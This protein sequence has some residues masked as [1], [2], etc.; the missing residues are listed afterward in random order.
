MPEATPSSP[1]NPAAN[2]LGLFS[3]EEI[4]AELVRRS[5]ALLVIRRFADEEHRFKQEIRCYFPPA[6][7]LQ[8]VINFTGMATMACFQNWIRY[9]PGQEGF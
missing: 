5:D 6:F 7:I 9:H 3:S 1:T 4:I 8:D 2:P